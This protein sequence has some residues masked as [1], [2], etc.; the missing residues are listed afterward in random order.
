MNT[1][2]E[3][4]PSVAAFRQVH[5]DQQR[6]ARWLDC[7]EGPHWDV[8][9]AAG[10]WDDLLSLHTELG[11]ECPAAR[12]YQPDR[13]RRWDGTYVDA[14]SAWGLSVEDAS[15]LG[16]A[17]SLDR[18]LDDESGAAITREFRDLDQAWVEEAARRRCR[19][20]LAYAALIEGA[21]GEELPRDVVEAYT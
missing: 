2:A 6:G 7:H 21:A 9:V 4:H 3:V 11:D 16:F 8:L 1:T 20:L 18:T 5:E 13:A 10:G 15:K 12:V 17:V 19:R 14:I